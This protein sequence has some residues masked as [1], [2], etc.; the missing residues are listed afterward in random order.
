M[1]VVNKTP[2]IVP[3]DAYD[4]TT[5]DGNLEVPTKNAIRDKIQTLT[6]TG[7]VVGPSSSVDNGIPRFDGTTGKLLQT[8]TKIT[9]DDNG[10][11]MFGADVVPNKSFSVS[12]AFVGPKTGSQSGTTVTATTS[13]FSNAQ[14]GHQ[15]I[16]DDGTIRRIVSVTSNTV[17]EVAQSGTV[18]SQTFYVHRS[19]L[20]VDAATGVSPSNVVTFGTTDIPSGTRFYVFGGTNGA[21]LDVRGWAGGSTDQ[22]IIELE[23]NDYDSAAKS[24]AMQYQG[25]TATGTTFGIT[26]AN[27]G[28][29]RNYGDN[30][31][32]YN[33]QNVPIKFGVNST[34][35]FQLTD[36]I[37]S[38]L[39]NDGLALGSTSLKWSDLHLAS[40][41][42][43]N[44]NNGDVTLTHSSGLVTLSGLL[45]TS[46]YITVGGGIRTA[47][48]MYVDT[49]TTGDIYLRPGFT[50]AV[51]VKQSTG[52]TGFGGTLT[53]RKTVDI[54]NAS[55]AQLR[56]TYTDNSVYTD[57]Q[58]DSSGNLTITP[59]GGTAVL[60]A[61][62]GLGTKNIITDTTTGTK[63]GT[64]TNQKLGFFN[65]TP[66][67]QPTGDVIIALQNLGLLAS[68][69]ITAT[70]ITS[71]TL[72]GQT[73]DGSANVTGSLT[74]VAD[75]TGGASSMT[76]TAGT[77][78]SR[79]LT[80]R[81]TTSGG[82]AT[83]FLT[84]NADQSSTFGGNISGTGAWTLTGGAGNMT[85]VSG[86]GN[87]RTMILQTTTSG[88]SATTALTL[89]ADQSATF[90]AGAAVGGT[91]ALGANSITM[92]G[93][94]GVTG[95]R[96]TKLWAANGEFTNPPTVGGVA[97]PTLAANQTFTGIETFSPTARSSGSAAYFTI[98]IPADTGITTA[99]EAI[100]F[101]TVTAT[102]TWVDGTVTLQRENFFAGPTYNKTTT[103]ATFTTAVNVDIAD[104]IAGTGVT[105]TNTFGLRV[106]NMQVTGKL[107][108]PTNGQIL[109]SVP[110][111]DG[112]AT[113]P[114]TNAFNS[115]YSSSAVGDLVYL[116]SSATW[117]KAKADA[118][119][120]C[121]GMLGIALEVKASGNALL[122]ALPGSF[123]YATAFPTFTVGGVVYISDST[124][125]AVT[126]T[127][128]TTTDHVIRVV[129]YGFHADKLA[130]LPSG[131]WV[132]HT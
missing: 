90:A 102:R 72:W 60:V 91:L 84:G 24:I 130:F 51:F 10:W 36:S 28:Q 76:I 47:A 13:S 116:D 21:N 34:L 22:A 23:G 25:S 78:N 31:L 132:T 29:L 95:T 43:V 15:I 107:S 113:G 1:A 125:G 17:A 94:I 83:A 8:S 101:K 44:F 19:A 119:S 86:T 27:L 124:S 33:A 112:H 57:F 104:P 89:N 115:G 97:L 59:T 67:V 129:G 81:S 63:I 5:W 70:S 85:I 92:S 11:A 103:S 75:I 2:V 41:A 12:P 64:A 14:E 6:G 38:P 98:N 110:T 65:S 56:L 131:D 9:V 80:L 62:L 30:F 4:A 32:I 26:N 121:T 111:T 53:P 50:T 93:S 123:V 66:I 73:Y 96:V 88:G 35:N 48:D 54:L 61:S 118:S 120:T 122:V 127:Q 109:L 7:D 40:G 16:F 82:T 128:P 126:Q 77:G 69:T 18:G 39:T 37:I 52:Y 100:G 87:S 99:T 105:F 74:A 114:T 79:T 106:A 46:S 55:V 42:V 71:R 68:G 58:T 20:F 45:T 108:L 117:Q 49:N 3:D